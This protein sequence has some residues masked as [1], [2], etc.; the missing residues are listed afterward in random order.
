MFSQVEFETSLEDGSPIRAK[1]RLI[2][3]TQL[4]QQLFVPPSASVIFSLAS[5]NY[6]FV[7]YTAARTALGDACSSTSTDRNERL[8][9]LNRSD[10]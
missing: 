2:Y 6:E 8:L 9:L 10:L 4:M 7:A 3:T 5:S 1:R